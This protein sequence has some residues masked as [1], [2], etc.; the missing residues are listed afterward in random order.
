ML[1]RKVN[2]DEFVDAYDV[3]E[4]MF[5]PWSDVVSTPFGAA[6]LVVE[7]GQRTKPHNHHEQETFFIVSGRGKMTYDGESLDVEPGHVAYFPA[8]GD[9]ILENTSADE[10]LHFLTIWWE[11]ESVVSALKDGSAAGKTSGAVKDLVAVSL[12]AAP[13]AQSAAAVMARYL[14]LRGARARLALTPAPAAAGA[15]ATAA[16]PAC[17][18]LRRLAAAGAITVDAQGVTFAPAQFAA[19]VRSHYDQATMSPR[20]RALVDA[21]LLR[22]AAV[23]TLARPAAAGAPVPLPG[24]TDHRLEPWFE[25][26]ARVLATP[27]GE[28]RPVVFVGAEGWS[29]AGLLP[30]LAAAAGKTWA[31]VALVDLTEAGAALPEWAATGE[32]PAAWTAWL[33]NLGANL[34][35]DDAGKVP[36]TQAWTT[37]QQRFMARLLRYVDEA[38][39]AY[40]PATFSPREAA[41]VLSDLVR[42]AGEYADRERPWNGI[43]NRREER[44]TAVALEALAAKVLAFLAQPLLPAWSDRLWQALGYSR[45]LGAGSWETTPTFVPTGSAAAGLAELAGPAPVPAAA[46]LAVAGA[47]S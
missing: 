22:G 17:D 47:P 44:N 15:D 42:T 2:P 26:A 7:P 33:G 11:D 31:P 8:F 14:L 28:E 38:G 1:I 3:K 41:R 45:P 36:P 18:L 46:P 4:Q 21:Q 40:D 25:S 39:A 27:R 6:W 34:V 32:P 13:A 24:F 30:A 20:L 37:E 19:A 43:A 29:E 9:H 23:A 10:D 35:R 16:A 12:A 5:Y